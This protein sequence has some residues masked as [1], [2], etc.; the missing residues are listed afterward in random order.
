MGVINYNALW[1]AVIMCGGLIL[2]SVICFGAA[3]LLGKEPRQR[4]R[5]DIE[6][7]KYIPPKNCI[8]KSYHKFVYLRTIRGGID[9][10]QCL[11][12]YEGKKC[13]VTTI[14]ER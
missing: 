9:E 5:Q 2:I 11:N 4:D 6:K 14:I 8:N 12:E 7:I 13:L 3:W 1:F 10:Y